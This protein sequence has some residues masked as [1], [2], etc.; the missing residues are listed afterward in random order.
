MGANGPEDV[1][2]IVVGRDRPPEGQVQ[3]PGDEEEDV[4]HPDGGAPHPKELLRAAL[5]GWRDA[6]SSRG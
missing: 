2:L 1:G 5:E 4:D 3:G 6:S